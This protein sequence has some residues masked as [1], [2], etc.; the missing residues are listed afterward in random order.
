M[1]F[2]LERSDEYR[3]TYRFQSRASA[4]RSYQFRVNVDSPIYPFS[5]G[6]SRVVVVRVR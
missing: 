6:T 2:K 4:G 1:H 5:P 3:W